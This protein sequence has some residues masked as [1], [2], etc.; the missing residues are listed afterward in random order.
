MFAIVLSS[1]T[2]TILYFISSVTRRKIKNNQSIQI[3][4]ID[5]FRDLPQYFDAYAAG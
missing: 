5:I 2:T 1:F 3:L 4:I